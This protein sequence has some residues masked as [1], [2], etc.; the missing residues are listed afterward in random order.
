MSEHLFL[1]ST[2]SRLLLNAINVGAGKSDLVFEEAADAAVTWR[3]S[4]PTVGQ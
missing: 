2:A 3:T 1:P 4:Q